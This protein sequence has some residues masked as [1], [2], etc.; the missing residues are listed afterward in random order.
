MPVQHALLEPYYYR[1]IIGAYEVIVNPVA[2]LA[3]EDA[4]KKLGRDLVRQ[5]H[6]RPAVHGS[7]VQR[8]AETRVPCCGAVKDSRLDGHVDAVGRGLCQG[9]SL[10][11]AC[12]RRCRADRAACNRRV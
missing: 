1:P 8:R 4:V 6:I 10:C 11:S 9:G 12:T 7:R 5:R 3:G 2:G